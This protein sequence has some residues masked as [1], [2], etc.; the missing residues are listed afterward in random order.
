MAAV[1]SPEEVETVWPA[2]PLREW[3]DTYETLHR[4]CQIVG[5]TC[6]ALAPFQNH[7]WHCALHLSEHGLRTQTLFHQQRLIELEFDF[8]DSALIARTSDGAAGRVELAPRSVADFY[9]EYLDLVNTLG[10]SH[11]IRAIP[12]EM[13]DTLPFA[14]DTLHSAYDAQSARR[15]WQILLLADRVL[16]QFRSR[17]YGKCSPSHFWWG[18][19]DLACT[20]FSGQPAPKHPGGV[21]NLPDWVTREAYSHECISAGWWPGNVGGPVSEPAFYAYAYPEPPGCPTAEVRPAAA[22]YDLTLHEWILPYEAVRTARD[23]DAELMAFLESTYDAAAR[24][25]QWD[26]ALVQMNPPG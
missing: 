5:K 9:A 19:F 23:P 16:K 10:F 6:L 18:G 13:P 4:W 25:G 22:R 3:Q 24:L 26:L 2:L 1:M 14:G 17:F 7:W 11:K 15:C 8:I 12:S 21:P 20:R